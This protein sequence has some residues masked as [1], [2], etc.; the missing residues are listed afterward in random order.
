MYYPEQLWS[1]DNNWQIV[2]ETES[3]FCELEDETHNY[4]Q[5]AMP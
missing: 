1:T 4:L 2:V 5:T 3:R